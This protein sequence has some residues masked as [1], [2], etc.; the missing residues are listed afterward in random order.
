MY[1]I[2]VLL[3]AYMSSVSKSHQIDMTSGPILV[4]L[5]GFSIP[6]I[7]SSALQLL[8]NAADVIVLGR[9]A[10][11]N[12]LAAVGSTGALIN[13][14]VNLF[15]GISV[16]TNVVTAH[17]FGAGRKSE[18]EQSVHTAVLVSVYSGIILTV[19]GIIGTRFILQFMQVPVEVFDLASLYLK[20]YFGGITAS[21]VYNFGSALLRAKGDTR[22]PM[23]YLLFAGIINVI[24]NLFFVIVFKMDVAGVALATMLSQCVAAVLVIRALM[25]EEGEFHLDLRRLRIE[26]GILLQVIKIGVPA[27]FQGMMFSISNIV[28]QS[29]INTFGAQVVA[30]SAAAGNIEGF[31]YTAMNGFAQGALTFSSQNLG[32]GRLDRVK[33]AVVVSEL[34]VMVTGLMLGGIVFLFRKFFLGLY[35]DNPAVIATGSSRITIICLLY[36]LCGMMET[37]AN[38]VRGL[39]HSLLPMII[40]L[41]GVCGMRVLWIVTIFQ[42]PRFHTFE[43]LFYSYPVTWTITL[44]CHALSLMII[45][46]KYAATGQK[47]FSL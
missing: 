34:S 13:L 25:K 39:G 17:F 6:L 19:V 7:F 24:L 21:M 40:S 27:G 37:T 32:A 3:L 42:V 9:F 31:I 2:L 30:G 14:M 5:L 46:R 47:G 18:V 43:V 20:V 26:R 22:R 45:F 15:V 8:F 36:A 38:I 1:F 10:G 41:A 16:G 44:L 28:I 11:E 29:A 4:K 35:S 23:F 33:R 12:S